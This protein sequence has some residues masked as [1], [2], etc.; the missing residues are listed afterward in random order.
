LALKRAMMEAYAP[1]APL[2][3]PALAAEI[4]DEL[5]EA[6]NP[7]HLADALYAASL[8]SWLMG[9]E[10]ELRTF[11]EEF[12]HVVVGLPAN[13]LTLACHLTQT[14]VLLSQDDPEALRAH[15]HQGVELA[16]SIDADGWA[17]LMRVELLADPAYDIERGISEARD[18]LGSLRPFNM[19]TGFVVTSATYL[20]AG[21]LAR[22]GGP[23][24]LEEAYRLVRGL[25]KTI[26]RVL[27]GRWVGQLGALAICDERPADGAR[28]M[29][30]WDESARR[31]G[32]DFVLSRRNLAALRA[33]LEQ[34]IGAATIEALASEGA[35]LTPDQAYDLA[36]NLG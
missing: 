13:R 2:H 7:Q 32:V 9:R 15:L 22:R 25:E 30:Y 21:W 14:Y 11:A 33:E 12:A 8:A 3:V 36:M 1:L 20:L 23:G 18:L 35:R 29:G 24:D 27:P 16:R 31:V 28:L 10:A 34:H 17:N 5:R 26:G 19:F 6:G 4:L